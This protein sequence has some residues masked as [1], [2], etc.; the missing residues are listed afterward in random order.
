MRRVWLCQTRR[1]KG[2]YDLTRSKR[3]C[4]PLAGCGTRLTVDPGRNPKADRLLRVASQACVN[5][6]CARKPRKCPAVRIERRMP[7]QSRGHGTRRT[8]PT[9]WWRIGIVMGAECGKDS[10]ACTARKGFRAERRWADG[11][12]GPTG[13][14]TQPTPDAEMGRRGRRPYPPQPM[15]GR[16]DGGRQR[17]RFR[18]V[19]LTRKIC[20]G[21][22]LA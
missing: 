7:T 11:G 6:Q 19:N 9:C 8:C 16:G 15:H 5:R 4:Q 3:V 2:Q 18:A 10:A 13:A 22:F 17:R 1:V 21:S 20:Q 12:V 14:R